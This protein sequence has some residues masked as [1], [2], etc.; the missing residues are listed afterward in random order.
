MEVVMLVRNR[1]IGAASRSALFS[2]VALAA[3]ISMTGNAFAVSL[4]VQIACAT[5]YYAHCSAYSPT[6]NEV[7]TCMRAVGNALSKRCVDALVAAGEV[8]AKEVARR[9]GVSETAAK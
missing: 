2:F 7:R 4:K 3:G 1:A 5:D 8:S 6:S 9:R